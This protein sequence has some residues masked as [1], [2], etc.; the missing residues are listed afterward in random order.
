MQ[1]TSLGFVP[2]Q[3]NSAIIFVRFN[4]TDNDKAVCPVASGS[5]ISKSSLE[6]INFYTVAKSSSIIAFLNC[7]AGEL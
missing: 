1:V 2:L 6:C 3:S 4:F 7:L 5:S